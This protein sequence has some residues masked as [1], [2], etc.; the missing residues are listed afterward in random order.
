M[1]IS[2]LNVQLN[3]SLLTK[4]IDVFALPPIVWQE[5]N[6]ITVSVHGT[7]LYFISLISDQI[8]HT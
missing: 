2:A 7:L 1:T 3:C 6:L 8:S 4:N 5:F